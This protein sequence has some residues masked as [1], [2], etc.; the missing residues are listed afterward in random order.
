MA[1][2]YRRRFKRYQSAMQNALSEVVSAPSAQAHSR[3][4]ILSQREKHV[5]QEALSSM[6]ALLHQGVQLAFLMFWFWSKKDIM[7]TPL[8]IPQ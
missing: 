3:L 4:P 8:R 2:F 6:S 1:K 7:Q 5:S